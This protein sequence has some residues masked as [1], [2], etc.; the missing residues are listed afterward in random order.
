MLDTFKWPNCFMK[1][2]LNSKLE[3]I[4]CVRS[5]QLFTTHWFVSIFQLGSWRKLAQIEEN[6]MRIWKFA[7]FGT[8]FL[9]NQTVFGKSA[10]ST[11]DDS[12]KSVWHCILSNFWPR[13]TV[14]LAP[15][16]AT[17]WDFGPGN[18]VKTPYANGKIG[19]LRG[20]RTLRLIESDS[21]GWLFRDNI[22]GGRYAEI[23]PSWES[24]MW[25]SCLELQTRRVV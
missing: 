13:I 7:V 12:G 11:P 15:S 14:F 3:T 8:D 2:Q 23:E 17:F 1:F 9:I 22:K 4:E 20:P 19:I 6:L 25:N 16:N 24:V 18:S 21:I 5:V 10:S